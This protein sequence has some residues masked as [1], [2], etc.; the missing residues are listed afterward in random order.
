MADGLYS[1]RRK[2]TT[3]AQADLTRHRILTVN[4]DPFGVLNSRDASGYASVD[5]NDPSGLIPA[6]SSEGGEH[7]QM[8][9]E[10]PDKRPTLGFEF[11]LFTKGMDVL[12]GPIAQAA[13]GGFD[14]TVWAMI[15]NTM[16]SD[17]SA[18]PVWASFATLTGVN[19]N[20]L[21]HSFDV[22]TTLLRFQFGN[23]AFNGSL[24]I[25]FSEL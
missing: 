11:C 12:Q 21:Y 5:P 7:F 24:A 15:G 20:Q 8:S 16:L 23:I 1:A 2:S 22:N 13:P 18:L 10:T 17:G 3:V 14:V 19:L 6:D 25:A 4:T 9:P